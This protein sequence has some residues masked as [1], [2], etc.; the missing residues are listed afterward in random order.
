MNKIIGI[1]FQYIYILYLDRVNIFHLILLYFVS[2]RNTAAR[3][4][5][6][7]YLNENV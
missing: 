4:L 5:K 7:K 1:N 6:W 2:Q 3:N